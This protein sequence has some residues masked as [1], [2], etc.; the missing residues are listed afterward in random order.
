[1]G[2]E[3]HGSN[4]WHLPAMRCG[5]CNR[6]HACPLA[7]PTLDISGKLNEK[8][9]ES[10]WPVSRM[11]FEELASPLKKLVDKD[12]PLLPGMGFG[13]F[14]GPIRRR[15]GRD[16]LWVLDFILILKESA[17]MRLKDAGIQLVVGPAV[18][19]YSNKREVSPD[20]KHVVEA[21]PV[22][23]MSPEMFKHTEY[24][25]CSECGRTIVARPKLLYLKKE[26]VPSE[27]PLFAVLETHQLVV[28]EAFAATVTELKLTNIA[29][30]PVAIV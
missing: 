30:E 20:Y 5:T 16:F 1:M 29:F 18:I 2:E 4:R 11:K 13:E 24:A 3:G 22:E 21:R 10:R 28:N 25:D 26:S 8:Q 19:N 23:C 27:L 12:M 14:R 7:Y 6:P 15:E 9:Y 17:Y